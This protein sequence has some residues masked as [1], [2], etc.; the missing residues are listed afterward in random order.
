MAR[1]QRLAACSLI[2]A[3]LSGFASAAAAGGAP[4][5]C[6]MTADIVSVCPLERHGADGTR[7][8]AI[9][10]MYANLTTASG[11]FTLCGSAS[12]SG[13]A[14][15]TRLLADDIRQ[16]GDVSQMGQMTFAVACA[17]PTVVT[18]RP[19]V[20]FW[21]ADGA[22]G[23]PGT[24]VGGVTFNPVIF[25]ANSSTLLGTDL[26]SLNFVLPQ[27]FWAGIVFDAGGAGS[28]TATIAQ[29]NALGLTKFDP[30]STSSRPPRQTG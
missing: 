1:V 27:N 16:F 9:G 17:S 29:L 21:L 13:A 7:T 20:R 14:A 3:G 6:T 4:P 5:E 12:G 19:R 30:P 23:L 25:A 2:A 18:A 15:I 26:T 11:G 22:G 28:A 10:T 8:G 24:Y